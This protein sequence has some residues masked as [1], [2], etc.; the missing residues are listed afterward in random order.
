MNHKSMISEEKSFLYA[1]TVVCITDEN[2]KIR[3]FLL[4][5]RYTSHLQCARRS[6][7]QTKTK[8]LQPSF[9]K[10]TYGTPSKHTSGTGNQ[11]VVRFEHQEILNLTTFLRIPTGRK[12]TGEQK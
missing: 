1:H 8:Q 6:Y 5:L 3:K 12:F 10:T 9:S 11:S 7:T 2:L 4:R